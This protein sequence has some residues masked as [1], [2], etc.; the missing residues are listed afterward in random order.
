MHL[1]FLY[2]AAIHRFN[3]RIVLKWANYVSTAVEARGI[4]PTLYILL[5]FCYSEM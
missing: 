4:L 3:I 2:H 5:E 1:T